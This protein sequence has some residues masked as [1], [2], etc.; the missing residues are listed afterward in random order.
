MSVEESV[1]R[2]GDVYF[3][4]YFALAIIKRLRNNDEKR[5]I[6]YVQMQQKN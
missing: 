4:D 2:K 1:Q 6:F 5:Q 3:S